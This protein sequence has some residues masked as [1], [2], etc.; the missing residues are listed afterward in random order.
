MEFCPLLLS[1]GQLCDIRDINH[2]GIKSIPYPGSANEGC[3]VQRALLM[4][5][6]YIE[7]ELAWSRW[8]HNKCLDFVIFS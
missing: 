6:C 8:V 7:V 3:V 4:A 2:P 5:Q 1:I